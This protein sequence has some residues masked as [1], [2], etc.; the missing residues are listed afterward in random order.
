MFGLDPINLML[1]TLFVG[2]LSL[3]V[4][5]DLYELRIPNQVS[6]ALVALYPVHVISS[7][8]AVDWVSAL[9]ATVAVFGVGLIA[10]MFGVFGGG[11]VKLLTA[12][13]LWCGLDGMFDLLV[14]TGV[15]G[16]VIAF[17]MVSKVRFSIAW[18]L[19]VLGERLVRDALLGRAIPYGIAIA[20]AA[21]ITASDSV[22]AIGS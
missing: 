10:F 9:L 6:L 15:I 18:G 7:P 19:D 22:L 14:L 4:V 12:A 2:L 13:T 21:G 8:V 16:G 5:S 17:V 3:A 20:I 11:D 1:A